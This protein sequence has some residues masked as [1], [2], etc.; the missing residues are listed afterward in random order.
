MSQINLEYE[1]SLLEQFYTHELILKD[2]PK[3]TGEEEKAYQIR[4]EI[5]REMIIDNELE[6]IRKMSNI[7]EVED[8]YID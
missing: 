8:F 7:K 3:S 6:K 1:K 5:I 2:Y 4:I